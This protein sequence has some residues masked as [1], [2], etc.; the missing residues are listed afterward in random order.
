MSRRKHAFVDTTND[1]NGY[2]AVLGALG[3]IKNGC[4]PIN[5]NHQEAFNAAPNASNKMVS[6]LLITWEGTL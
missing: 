4:S 5:A 6:F 1:C 2:F 3:P